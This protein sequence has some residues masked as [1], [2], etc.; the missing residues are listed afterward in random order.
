MQKYTIVTCKSL[1]FHILNTGQWSEN[2]RST[3]VLA[4]SNMSAISQW[5]LVSR[6]ASRH[7]Q[8]WWDQVTSYCSDT[9]EPL[10]METSTINL[11]RVHISLTHSWSWALLEKPPIVQPLENFPEFYGTRT[12]ITVLTGTLHWLLLLLL[13]FILAANGFSPGGSGTTIRHSTQIT[14]VTQYKTPRSNKTQH[15]KLHKQQRTHYTQ[16]TQWKY[17]YNYSKY[18]YNYNYINEIWILIK[19]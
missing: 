19:N 5:D 6:W 12:F 10:R 7:G 9:L 11:L 1:L 8:L 4:T 14:H 2:G 18:N 3:L 17:T 15:T 13:L 16:W